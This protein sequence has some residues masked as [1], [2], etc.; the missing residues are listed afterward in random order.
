M[1]CI[2]LL[3]KSIPTDRIYYM[4]SR[5]VTTRAH[6][7]IYDIVVMLVPSVVIIIYILCLHK[8]IILL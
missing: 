5:I 2:L 7:S 4:L 6:V 3:N 8:K 1:F